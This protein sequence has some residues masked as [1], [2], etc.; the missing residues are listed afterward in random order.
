MPAPGNDSII[1]GTGADIMIG[2]AG[3]DSIYFHFGNGI[4]SSGHD[5]LRDTPAK[6]ERR[7]VWGFGSGFT[8]TVDI[9]GVQF[10][11]VGLLVSGNHQSTTLS[12]RRGDRPVNGCFTKRRIH[13][14]YPRQRRSGTHGVAS[15]STCPP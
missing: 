15:C 13:D 2:G 14:R 11:Q 9:Q 6:P 8:S 7:S 1:A 4:I 12:F 3:A 5:I 10:N